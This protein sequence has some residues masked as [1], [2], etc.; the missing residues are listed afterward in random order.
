MSDVGYGR[1]PRHS[2]FKPGQSGNPAGRKAKSTLLI[3]SSARILS[4]PVK[5]RGKTGRNQTLRML[6]VSYLALC[7]KALGGD[8]SSLLVVM[9][10]LLLI[11]P[12]IDKANEAWLQE[13]EDARQ[14]IYQ[15][16]GITQ[17]AIDNFEKGRSTS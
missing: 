10:T 8:R 16:L 2:Q 14:A 15:K 6:E 13:V 4:V 7:R 1:P 11:G 9:R 17:E 12:E 5:T 3:E